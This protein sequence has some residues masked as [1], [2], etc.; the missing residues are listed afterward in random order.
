MNEHPSDPG[1]RLAVMIHRLVRFEV[2]KLRERVDELE[3]HVAD[4]EDE[5]RIMKQAVM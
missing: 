2:E 3:A 1:E 4:L 5:L